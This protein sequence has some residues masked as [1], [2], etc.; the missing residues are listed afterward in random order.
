MNLCMKKIISF[1]IPATVIIAG[2]KPAVKNTDAKN[3]ADSTRFY[4]IEYFWNSQ[5]RA[6]DSSP[7]YIYKIIVSG[8]KKDSS[9]INNGECRQFA[10]YFSQINTEN[11]I[12]KKN[13]KESVF[14]DAST[15]S[16]TFNYSSLY[17]SL[18]LKSIDIL[19]DQNTQDVKRVFLRKSFVKNDTL[20]TESAGWKTDA[21][22]Y[23]NTTKEIKDKPA[24]S[25][26]L[27]VVWNQNN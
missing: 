13:Y 24:V 11:E 4:P 20:F 26:Q 21:N 12:F 25:Q 22:F 23:I 18:P 19:I 17:D 27:I 8:K 1:L 15:G 16:I 5:L 7:F 10:T 3:N 2:C 9:E 14:N 6:I